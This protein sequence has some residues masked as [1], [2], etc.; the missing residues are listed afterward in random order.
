[1]DNNIVEDVI[2]DGRSTVNIM[3]EELQKWLGFFN[4]KPT[5]STL[6]MVDQTITK[7][8]G[9]IKDLK[10]L[11]HGIPYIATFT[12][13]KNNVLDSNYSHYEKSRMLKPHY[14]PIKTQKKTHIKLL[15]NCVK[16][17]KGG[18]HNLV[19]AC[20]IISYGPWKKI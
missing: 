20:W 16:T 8:V 1:V 5:L 15:C 4:P 2:L 13:M 17:H 12:I 6:K 19:T 7:L 10:I 11:I 14:L 3:M 18:V 9:L